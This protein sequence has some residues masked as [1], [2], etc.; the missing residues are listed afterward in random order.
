MALN[1]WMHSKNIYKTPPNFKQMAIDYPEFRKIVTQDVAGKV[2]IDFGDPKA[3]A[4][5]AE[6]LFRKTFPT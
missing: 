2:L 4:C 5:L 6:V 3:L 1:K